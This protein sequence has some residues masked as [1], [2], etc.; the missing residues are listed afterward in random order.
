MSHLMRRRLGSPPTGNIAS[1]S[2]SSS[3][4][5]P[6]KSHDRLLDDK[7]GCD[8]R[9]CETMLSEIEPVDTSSMVPTTSEQQNGTKSPIQVESSDL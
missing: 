8:E 9:L 5:S 7:E 3:V 2:L 1:D 6:S 4:T